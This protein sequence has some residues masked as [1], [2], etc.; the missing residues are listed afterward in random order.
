M[1][2]GVESLRPEHPRPRQ[3]S[4]LA[5]MLGVSDFH[6]VSAEVSG[7]AASSGEVRPGDVFFALP[8]AKVHG[9]TFALD[10]IARGA[11]AVVTDGVG[12]AL[13]ADATTPILAIERVC[14]PHRSRCPRA[15]RG[16]RHQWKDD[17]GVS[18]C[19]ATGTNRLYDRPELDGRTTYRCR[20]F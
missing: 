16:D 11:V 19:R 18:D 14:V 12:A 13:L 9:A 2:S 3:L 1:A 15:L 6:A 10:A 7:V 20:R 8:G 5:L 17:G 4:E